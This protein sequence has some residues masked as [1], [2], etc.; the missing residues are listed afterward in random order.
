MGRNHIFC[1]RG[2]A[3]KGGERRVVPAG[4]KDRELLQVNFPG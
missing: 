3:G 4:E 2:G 1:G